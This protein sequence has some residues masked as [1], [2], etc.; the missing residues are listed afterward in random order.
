MEVPKLGVESKLRAYTTATA[1]PDPSR[2]YDVHHTYG[3][4]GSLTHGARPGMEPASSWILARFL[5]C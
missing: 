4:A 3:N 2:I 1:T 5:T